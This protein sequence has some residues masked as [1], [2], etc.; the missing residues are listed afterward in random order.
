MKYMK[1][2]ILTTVAVLMCVIGAFA[3][4]SITL[5]PAVR[6]G[7]LDNGLTY[8]IRHNAEPQGQAN[9]YIAQKVGSILEEENQR[10]LAHFLE[11]MC[12]NGTEHFPGNGVIKYCESIGVK[13]GVNLNAVTS[14]DKTIYNIDNVPVGAIP[15]SVDSCLWIL[16]DW[17]NGLLLTADDIDHE[18][19]VIHEEWRSTSSASK[20]MAEQIF[21]MV[22]PVGTNHPCPDGS[23]RYG[24]RMPIGLMS[25]VDNFPYKALRDYYE[26]WYRPDLQAIVVVGDINVDEIEAKIQDIFGKIA[27]PENPAER[28]YVEIP[29]NEKPIICIAKDKEQS[30]A[31]TY[32][33]FKHEQYPVGMRGEVYYLVY[34]YILNAATNMLNARLDEMRQGANPPFINAVVFDDNFLIA[35]TK[36]AFGGDVISSAEGLD[37][38]V[39]TLYREMLRAVRCGFTASEYERAKARI[40][41]NA[42]VDY[43]GRDKKK[44]AEYCSEYVQN[45][46]DNEPIASAEVEFDIIQRIAN[47]ADVNMVNK[48]L[49][50]VVGQNNL[51]VCLMLPDKEG[52]KYPTNEEVEAM[53]ADV[54]AEDIAPYVDNVSIE[55]LISDLP[56]PGRVVKTE[57]AKLGYKK[58]TLSNGVAVYFRQTDFNPNEVLM[59]AVSDGGT[60]LYPAS[61]I[62][63]LKS[64]NELM[65]I[66]GVGKFSMTELKKMLAGRKV[67]AMLQVGLFDEVISMETT[68]K[69][70]ETMFQL[71]YLYF[72]DMRADNEAFE[73]WKTRERAV[74]ANRESQPTAALQDSVNA[75]IQTDHR[76]IDALTT[77]ELDKIDYSRAMQI[78]RER[79]ANAADFTFV[80]TGAID[81]ATLMPLLEQYVAPLPA[82]KKREKPD[83]KVMNFKHGGGK[84]VF[85]REMD[86]PLATNVFFDFG[87]I[88]FTLKNRIAFNLA[89][90]SLSV[91]LMEEIR[92]KESGTY[93]IRANGALIMNPAPRQQ[94]IM[95][96]VYQANP[97]RY[98]YLNQ[99]VREIVDKFVKEGP[100]AENLAKSKEFFLK[101]YKESLR[102]NS[103]WQNALST[104]LSTK[105]DVATDFESVLQSITADDV[106]QVFEKLK[107]QNN[108]SEIIMVG[109]DRQK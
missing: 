18:R 69:D 21:P 92:E 91:E 97:D 87:E 7:H 65:G 66:G 38:A 13:F 51:V 28:Y 5:D 1:K 103:Y 9:F 107:K 26:K 86:V 72:T 63:E 30:A 85:N 106:R 49:A 89:L 78:A 34:K 81:E 109:K 46:I 31:E 27:K 98:E 17:S 75:T 15:S 14:L 44:S 108:H 59:T 105:V 45:F 83:L 94:A 12:F 37:K 90:N 11:H 64:L 71:G 10:G 70:I 54:A 58:Y 3:Q 99:R 36:R 84:K 4:Q 35:K 96:I 41:A 68:P 47:A 50:D 62:P 74:L 29:D 8:Y 100:S 93:D 56:K 53:L 60:S 42:E 20:R 22:Y 2:R 23:N 80:I 39:T 82:T 32:I 104:L 57:K 55:P 33:L 79:F 77:A 40:L 48:M 24:H 43:N 19:G 101:E 95:E 25:V 88:P 67:G 16:R 6:I 73:S 52:L 76:R 102:N 61:L